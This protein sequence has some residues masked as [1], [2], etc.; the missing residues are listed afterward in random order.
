[1]TLSSSTIDLLIKQFIKFKAT[2]HVPG[3]KID[4]PQLIKS[5]RPALKTLSSVTE[6]ET[7]DQ[8]CCDDLNNS[9]HPQLKPA[10]LDS[11]ENT[12]T[13]VE[14]NKR[15][16]TYLIGKNGWKIE[17][18]R[19]RSGARVKVVPLNN[20]SQGSTVRFNDPNVTQ[21]LRVTGTKSQVAKALKIIESEIEHFRLN[22]I[23]HY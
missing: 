23:V 14:L 18:I 1:M 2:P 10:E 20:H 15:E 22:E 17:T 19:T 9:Q 21:Y 7:K 8:S 16:V 13:L 5:I 11:E 4:T 3:S 6:F 12:W